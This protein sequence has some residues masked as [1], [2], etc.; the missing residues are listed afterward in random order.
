MNK[1]EIT[2]NRPFVH[3]RIDSKRIRFFTFAYELIPL[4]ADK[5]Y[6]SIKINPI[7]SGNLYKNL[8]S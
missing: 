2:N 1:M 7:F 5:M 8:I 3:F 4:K 6:V